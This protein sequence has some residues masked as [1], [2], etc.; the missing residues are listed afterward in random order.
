MG[1]HRCTQFSPEETFQNLAANQSRHA[2]QSRGRRWGLEFKVTEACRVRVTMFA[3]HCG[4]SVARVFFLGAR[5]R[6]DEFQLSDL[7]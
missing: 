3:L 6:I 7:V 5:F 1:D 4:D 2:P